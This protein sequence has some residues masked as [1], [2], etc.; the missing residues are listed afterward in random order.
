MT[1]KMIE[2]IEEVLMEEKPQIV[3]VYGDTNSTLAGALA[4]A[5]LHIPVAH[6][7]AGLRSFRID[8]P[9]EIN[10]VLTDRIST[11]LFCP[12]YKAYE[13]LKKEGAP[14]KIGEREKQKIY[15][16]G[17]VMKD[18]L[19]LFKKY[20]RKPSFDIPEKFVL[21]TV[22]REENTDIRENLENIINA[23]EKISERIPV[24]LPIHPRT[25]KRLKDFGL[26]TKGVKIV[27]PVS[28]LEM[29]YL[30][31]SSELVITDSGGLQKE[32]FLLGK[33]CI[34]LRKETEWVELVEG[35]YN[36]L[37]GAKKE[38]IIKSFN[39]MIQKKIRFSKKLYGDGKAHKKIADIIED[40]LQ[41]RK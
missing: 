39:H 27:P 8:M 33:K 21:A 15:V 41:R 6:V 7:E 14:H 36:I 25:R 32:A 4:S 26:K 23:L 38:K 17:D 24:I 10:R 37:A 2:K 5:K 34:T 13:N 29:L 28:Y 1:G 19:L 40:F 35:G 20:M 11:I 16:V 12:T 9:E 22:H 30:V 18:S 31:S 3:L